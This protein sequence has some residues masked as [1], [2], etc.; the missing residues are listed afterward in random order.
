MPRF[1][2]SL[3][4]Q[5]KVRLWLVSLACFAGG[6][7]GS[8]AVNAGVGNVGWSYPIEVEIQW[9]S[10]LAGL[11][12]WLLW[13][14]LQA[15]WRLVPLGCLIWVVLAVASFIFLISSIPK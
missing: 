3:C 5:L 8:L 12:T 14:A 6:Y 1:Q 4:N 9:Y 10:Y 15:E 13:L 11:A 2:F 7:V